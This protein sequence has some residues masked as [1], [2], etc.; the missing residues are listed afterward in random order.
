VKLIV[1]ITGSWSSVPAIVEGFPRRLL[2]FG[3]NDLL[4]IG[5]SIVA[6]FIYYNRIRIIFIRDTQ[7]EQQL[8]LI[9]T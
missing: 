7:R 5:V 9:H 2:G 1:S 3:S 8:F 4:K 6:N